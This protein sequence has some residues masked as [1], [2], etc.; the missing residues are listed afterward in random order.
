MALCSAIVALFYA[1]IV[2]CCCGIVS[3]AV[4]SFAGVLTLFSDVEASFSDVLVLFL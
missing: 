2:F 4:A 1:I 3:V